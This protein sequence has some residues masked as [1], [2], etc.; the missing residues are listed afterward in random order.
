MRI[1]LI[2]HGEMLANVIN[3]EGTILYTGAL[4]NELTTLTELGKKQASELA[5][6]E[7]IKCIEKVYSSD[8]KRTIQTAELAKPGYTLNLS[9]DLRER[10]LGEFEGKGIKD[11]QDF[12]KYKKYFADERFKNFRTSFINK[13]PNGESYT[14]V[15]D[16]CK[17]FLD[18][19]DFSQDITIGIFSHFHTIR[20][21]L[22][23]LLKIEPKEKI[24]NIKIKHCIPYV[25]E[26]NTIE[27]MK[28]V[29]H[30]GGIL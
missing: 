28:L 25:I 11:L 15:S 12:E 26:G 17:R 4:N 10:S 7:I 6:K 22:L 29:S 23:N 27:D 1:V 30:D 24:F 8:L 9:K 20:C 14:D 19:L 13:A 3:G 2:R 16:R 21:L 5:E 18:S